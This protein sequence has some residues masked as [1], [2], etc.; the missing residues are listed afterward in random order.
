M[1]D[2]ADT[3]APNNFQ[4][5]SVSATYDN[6]SESDEE[7]ELQVSFLSFYLIVHLL[8]HYI[9]LNFLEIEVVTM[10]FFLILA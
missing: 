10:I 1:A 4:F 8:Y 7:Q 6:E 9:I 5:D 3:F 2:S